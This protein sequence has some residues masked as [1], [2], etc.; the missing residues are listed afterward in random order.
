MALQNLNFQASVLEIDVKL[1]RTYNGR[2]WWQR[3][4]QCFGN[5]KVFTH[6]LTAP[7]GETPESLEAQK[8]LDSFQAG[9]Y[10]FNLS[11]GQGDRGRAVFNV[12]SVDFIQPLILNEGKK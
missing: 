1:L 10:Q 8:K 7:S 12:D 5:G 3:T 2:S 4:M 9:Q 6:N 11:V